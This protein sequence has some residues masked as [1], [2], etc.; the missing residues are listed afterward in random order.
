MKTSELTHD[1]HAILRAIRALTEADGRCDE[2]S[3]SIIRLADM[4]TEAIEEFWDKPSGSEPPD[5]GNETRQVPVKQHHT[6][7]V[8]RFLNPPQAAGL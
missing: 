6:G 3:T 2:V 4:G 1:I 5:G 7:P 8:D